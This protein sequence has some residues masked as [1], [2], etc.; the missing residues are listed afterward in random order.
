MSTENGHQHGSLN[1]LFEYPLMSAL[2]DRR[3]RRLAR[4]T[5][6]KAGPLSHES[7]NDPA[8]LS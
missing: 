3:T 1:D 5:S 2:V 8:P 6:M 7:K 4:G